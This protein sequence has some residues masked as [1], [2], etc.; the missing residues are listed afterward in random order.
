MSKCVSWT[1]DRNTQRA[2]RGH[3]LMADA[4][5]TEQE[6][7]RGHTRGHLWAYYQPSDVSAEE[8]LQEL[9]QEPLQLQPAVL[10]VLQMVTGVFSVGVGLLFAATQEMTTSLL[11]MFRVPHLTGMMFFSAG[12]STNLLFKY[13]QLLPVAL[14]MNCGC[15]VVAGAAACL[16]SIDLSHWNRQN[17]QHLKMEALQLGLLGV[18]VSLSTALCVLLLK[19]KRAKEP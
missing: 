11:T 9:L 12:V 6:P 7:S 16:V 15:I 10:G 1:S 14:M 13:P 18:E 5:A 4:Q 8:P 19:K 3:R 17:Q 2:K